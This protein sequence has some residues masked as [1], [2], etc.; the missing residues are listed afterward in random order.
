MKNIL[1]ITISLLFMIISGFFF[2]QTNTKKE[3]QP[4]ESIKHISFSSKLSTDFSDF[5][6]QYSYQTFTI[7][8]DESKQKNEGFSISGTT[9]GKKMEIFFDTTVA[10]LNER[11]C[12]DVCNEYNLVS[13]VFDQSFF[14]KESQIVVLISNSQEEYNYHFFKTLNE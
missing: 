13:D 6:T 5:P 4:D 8:V 10:T 2:F 11:V 14:S 1:P 7:K 9:A 3:A 12:L